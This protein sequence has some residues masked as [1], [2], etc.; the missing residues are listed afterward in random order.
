MNHITSIRCCATIYSVVEGNGIITWHT[1]GVG[2]I[3]W[4]GL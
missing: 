4:H 3:L 2:V 1:A